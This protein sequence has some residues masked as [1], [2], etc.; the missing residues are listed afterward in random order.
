MPQNL[1]Y[2]RT[3]WLNQSG[4]SWNSSESL[5]KLPQ[6]HTDGEIPSGKH[7]PQQRVQNRHR[8]EWEGSCKETSKRFVKWEGSSS[9]QRQKEPS[10]QRQLWSEG[11]GISLE[12]NFKWQDDGKGRDINTKKTPMIKSYEQPL[13]AVIFNATRD[14]IFS[15][16][17]A[18]FNHL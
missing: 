6:R 4:S 5:N 13:V 7:S 2:H 12:L 14:T 11:D 9:E 17:Y 3:P 16:W 15:Q 18:I 10:N 1:S 8:V